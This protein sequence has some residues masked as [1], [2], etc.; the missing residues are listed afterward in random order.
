MPPLVWF[1]NGLKFSVDKPPV[2]VHVLQEC[3]GRKS[4]WA[5]G[6]TQRSRKWA[7]DAQFPVVK[8][9]RVYLANGKKKFSL[10]L[11]RTRGPNVPRLFQTRGQDVTKPRT[12]GVISQQHLWDQSVS[13]MSKIK[14]D[15]LRSPTH[16]RMQNTVQY[17]YL[18][19]TVPWSFMHGR[20]RQS[21]ARL[22][23]QELNPAGGYNRLYV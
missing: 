2:P 17:F 23:L 15:A 1:L 14:Q 4:I 22:V 12:R 16:I 11:W 19:W 18:F 20:E 8:L 3:G 21:H 5:C 10:T 13:N 6:W 7:G 9:W